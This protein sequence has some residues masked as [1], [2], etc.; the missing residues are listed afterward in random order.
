[1]RAPFGVKVVRI[2]P[3]LVVLGFERTLQKTVPV[4]PR[5]LGRPAPGHEVAEVA[6][7]PRQVRIS[8]PKSRVQEVESA[9]TEPL[10]VAEAAADVSESLN[11][12]LEDPTLQIL[13]G[14]RVR[15]TARIREAHERRELSDL[16][17]AVR[18]G[19]ALL[20]PSR[21]R[22]LL[23]GPAALIARLSP[24]EV[25][26]YVDVTPLRGAGRVP[27]AVELAPGLTGV[28]VERTEPEQV[29]AKR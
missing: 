19:S 1:V 26:A 3:S 20:R 21:V 6:S 18:G 8:G 16:P 28:A 9:F 7:E 29:M 17:V 4:R 27:V 25:R 15:V 12:G 13:D 22:V 11:L 23:S 2:S 24:S 10:S 5:L 14:P